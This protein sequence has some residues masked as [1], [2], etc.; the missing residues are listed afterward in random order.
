MGVKTVS[1]KELAQHSTK[2]NAWLVIDGN[3]Y[4][5]SKFAMLHP[6]GEEILYEY[7]GQDVTETFYGLHR[8]EVLAKYAPKLLV[9][10]LEGTGE[11]ELSILPFAENTGFQGFDS[12]YWTESHVDFRRNVRQWLHD[13]V[14]DAAEEGEL[15][16]KAPT[17]ELFQLMGDVGLLAGRM[18]PGA[19]MKY[20]PKEL[21][22]LPK[23][24]FDYF[25]EMILHEEVGRLACPGFVDGIGSGM[26]IG[27]PPVLQF[28]PD[29]M[30]DKV[31]KEVL[32][33]E[34]R[35]CLAITEAFAGSDVAH[36]KTRAELSADG[37]HY[38]VN[39]TKKWITNGHDSHYFTTLVRTGG[40]G[41]GG[42]SFMLIERGEGVE[43]KK[44][45][46][47]YS[48]SA[49]TAYITFENV[50]VPAENL[51]G[52][53]NMGFLL[54]MYNFV[55]E[56][57][58]ICAYIN[59]GSRGMIDECL[60]WTQQRK[61]FGK[62][63]LSQ[64]VVRKQIGEM[65]SRV[66]AVSAWTENITYRMC[67]MPYHE[68]SSKLAGQVCLLKYECTRVAHDVADMAVQIFGGR[69]ITQSGMGKY[70]ERFMRTYKF[71]SILGGSEDVLIDA[72]LR[73]S[74]ATAAKE[75]G[76]LARA[77]L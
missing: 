56:R 54:S 55:H 40:E 3:V 68:M 39:G 76:N 17:Q 67:N 35:I 74:M 38:I 16:G 75:F 7:A 33:G 24:K 19:A 52:G 64:P 14:R 59:A 18:G 12:P 23:E 15:S 63:L 58:M 13:N 1:T 77:R 31:A 53:E 72:G 48:P 32:S 61:A 20:A 46:T 73:L 4:D 26:A 27:L 47:S 69:G 60:R 71:A 8:H 34:K 29:W 45:K 49:G 11:D 44:I 43:T 21:F 28:G 36:V 50:K 30:K 42:L 70:V 25:Y 9:G 66:E 57:W 51:I 62:P 41:H 37:T 22:G 65:I 10:R 5:V 2:E 6:G